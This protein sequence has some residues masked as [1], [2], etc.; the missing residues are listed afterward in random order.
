ALGG[1]V[2]SEPPLPLDTTRDFSS[3]RAVPLG[4]DFYSPPE[5]AKV[6]GKPDFGLCEQRRKPADFAAVTTGIARE[7]STK[8][9]TGTS[10]T[11]LKFRRRSTIGLRGSPENNTLIRY[12]AQHRSSR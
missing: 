4:N 1:D 10:P 11:S 9:A 7:S 3:S 2:L 6:G 8:R 5:R 12:L